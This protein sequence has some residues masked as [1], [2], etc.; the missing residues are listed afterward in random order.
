[1]T[2]RQIAELVG[3]S[4]EGDGDLEITGGNS[5]DRAGGHDLS[6]AEGD[7]G[8]QA[9]RK[10]Q[11]GALLIRPDVQCWRARVEGVEAGR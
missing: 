11:A 8:E 4:L 6:F 9:A 2:A 3:G 5:L 1:M 10:S 7:S